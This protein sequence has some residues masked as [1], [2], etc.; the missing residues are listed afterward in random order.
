[1]DM[2]IIRTYMDPWNKL[3]YSQG[4]EYCKDISN[5][6]SI[7]EICRAIFDI[8][9]LSDT[10]MNG[11]SVQ[12]LIRDNSNTDV[13]FTDIFYNNLK[14]YITP[15]QYA[16]DIIKK[17]LDIYNIDTNDIANVDINQ[18]A[19]IVGRGLV[20]FPSFVR[21]LDLSK[22]ISNVLPNAHCQ[23][24]DPTNDVIN[25][26]DILIEMNGIEYRLWS[27]VPSYRGLINTSRR[28][29]GCRGQIPDGIHVL[30]PINIRDNNV[31]EKHD[32]WIL[33]SN[34]YIEDLRQII[35]NNEPGH[36]NTIRNMLP[37]ELDE[38]LKEIEIFRK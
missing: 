29:L 14:N 1:M 3:T 7:K 33:Y 17:Y 26:T 16:V 5:D 27:Y 23:R 4:L 8:Q 34:A 12:N 38:Y 31:C 13:I 28:L 20:A 25:H 35:L 18:I 37:T 24:E 2:D 15:A 19:G 21:E 22:K 11:Y 10:R 32:G 9:N 30:C 6:S 36:Y